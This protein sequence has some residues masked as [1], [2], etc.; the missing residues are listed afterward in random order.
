MDQLN[1]GR[2]AGNIVGIMDGCDDYEK[3][4]ITMNLWINARWVLGSIDK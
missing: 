4:P 1:N 2:V 3:K